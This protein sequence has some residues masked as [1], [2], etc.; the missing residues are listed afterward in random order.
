MTADFGLNDTELTVECDADTDLLVR[1]S[2]LQT[3]VMRYS[4]SGQQ[5]E[6]GFS[7]PMSFQFGGDAVVMEAHSQ[8]FFGD[9]NREFF[10]ENGYGNPTEVSP[11]VWVGLCQPLGE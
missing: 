1:V 2:V 5:Y 9:S 7:A 8:T 3:G 10:L 11:A 6:A 4:I